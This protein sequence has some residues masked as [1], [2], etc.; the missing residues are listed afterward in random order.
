[1]AAKV[2]PEYHVSQFHPTRGY[3]ILQNLIYL[4]LFSTSSAHVKTLNEY[5]NAT[6]HR[7]KVLTKTAK[8]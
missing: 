7:S 6:N 5:L 1:M 2:H 8:F 4:K 3:Y